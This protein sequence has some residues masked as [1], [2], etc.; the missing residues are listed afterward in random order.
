[1][2]FRCYRTIFIQ[3]KAANQDYP[4]HPGLVIGDTIA[5]R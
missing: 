1:M 3:F 2:Q 4:I 5:D